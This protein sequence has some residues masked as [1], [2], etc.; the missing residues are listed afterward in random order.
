MSISIPITSV[1]YSLGNV[2]VPSQT[3][4]FQTYFVWILIFTVVSWVVQVA[5]IVYCLWR[6]ASFSFTDPP[7]SMTTS[8]ASHDVN[9]KPTGRKRRTIL[10][11]RARSILSLQWRSIAL[12]FI[13]ANLVLYFGMFFIQQTSTSRFQYQLSSPDLGPKG[14]NFDWISCLMANYHVEG[15]KEGC[16]HGASG[17]GLREIRVEATLIIAS[18]SLTSFSVLMGWLLTVGCWD[19]S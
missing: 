9:A 19:V 15:G 5:T 13:I 4:A 1:S 16:L 2:C 10:W 6:F 8:D 3:N 12:A 7:T 14:Q 18:V 11:A 17:F